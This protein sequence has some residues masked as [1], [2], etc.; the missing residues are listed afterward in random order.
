MPDYQYIARGATG[1]Q[2]TGKLTAA[3][4]AEAIQSLS[5]KS[6]FPVSVTEAKAKTSFGGGRVGPKQ[7]GPFFA[8]LADLL[9]A[10]VPLLRALELLQRQASHA[11]LAAV[12]KDIR[13]EVADGSRL[14]DAMRRHPRTFDDLA[15][16]MV[17]AGEEGGFL[18][19]VLKRIATF[20][21]HQE[22]LKGRVVGAIAYP[23]FLL[24]VGSIVVLVLVVWFV[25]KF[26]PMFERMQ[27]SG[28]LPLPTELLLTFSHTIGSEAGFWILAAVFGLLYAVYRYFQTDDGRRVMDTIRVKAPGAGGIYRNLAVSRFCRIL[29]TLLANGVPILN[30][31]RIAKDAAGNVV[32]KEAIGSAAENV[33][34]GESLAVPLQASGQFPREVIEMITV[35]E[36]ANTLESVLVDIADG[37]ERRTYRRLDLFVRL[38]EP[39][40]LLLMAGIVLFVVLALLMPVVNSSS[41]G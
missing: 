1:Q 33:S 29:G 15:V 10:G 31:L 8:G 9:K 4:Q 14:Y 24:G 5:A 2:V 36:E 7:T 26:E 38:L 37:I 30:S 17:R 23:A 25:P 22:E 28:G 12:L 20:S 19:D 13:G 11:G 3:S 32:L 40:M 18:E 39:L 27:D 21:E 34:Q 6:L 16:S 35:G 41:L